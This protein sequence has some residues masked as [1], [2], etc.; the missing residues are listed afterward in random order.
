MKKLKRGTHLSPSHLNDVFF[1][2]TCFCLLVT[3]CSY[4]FSCLNLQTVN[5]ACRIS[6]LVKKSPSS[7]L[8]MKDLFKKKQ[9]PAT[10]LYG[11]KHV[12]K[13][14]TQEKV[15]DS[16]E[17]HCFYGNNKAT[18]TCLLRIALNSVLLCM[19]MVGY[20]SSSTKDRKWLQH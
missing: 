3:P 14:I 8:K 19:W 18:G 6:L 16:I 13:T 17:V 9:F 11:M 5:F 20:S 2:Y 7:S 10:Y 4:C 1:L 15:E 12:E